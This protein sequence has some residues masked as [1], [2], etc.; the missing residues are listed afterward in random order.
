[1]N[2]KPAHY[3]VDVFQN[4]FPK[5]PAEFDVMSQIRLPD[6]ILMQTRVTEDITSY[7]RADKTLITDY[8]ACAISHKLLTAIQKDLQSKIAEMI[9]E[10]FKN[11][12]IKSI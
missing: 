6:G 9:W 10:R 12:D 8:V 2:S 5:H 7:I 11:Y 1:M 4:E 3:I